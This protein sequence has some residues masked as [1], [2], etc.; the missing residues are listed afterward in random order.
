ML[1]LPGRPQAFATLAFTLTAPPAFELALTARVVQIFDAPSGPNVAFQLVGWGAAR[2]AE[3]E[4]RLAAPPPAAADEG[5]SRG[6]S[7]VFRIKQ[8]DPAQRQRL[9]LKAD[10]T[11]RQI[12]VRDSS[13]L[14]LLSLLSNPLL[15]AEDVLA[16]VR[17]T[18][19]TTAILQRVAADRRWM[20]HAEIRSAVVRNPKTPTPLAVRLLETLPPSELRDLAK[21]GSI[22]EDVRRA[23]FRLHTRHGSGR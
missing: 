1:P 18:T 14:V 5:E 11:E 12:L 7:P 2:E 19:A 4:R 23:A 16:V 21:M 20:G 9:A 8:M 6:A 17:S 3:L 13:P 22:R 10:R 15:E